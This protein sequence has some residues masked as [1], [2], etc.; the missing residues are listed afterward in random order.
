MCVDGERRRERE[1]EREKKRDREKEKVHIHSLANLKS[2]EP[3]I[4]IFLQNSLFSK[5]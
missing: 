2:R 4:K 5:V 3:Y 1:H